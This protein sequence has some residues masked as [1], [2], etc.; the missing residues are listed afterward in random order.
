[1]HLWGNPVNSH[2]LSWLWA[3]QG[4]PP[5]PYSNFS[6]RWVRSKSIKQQR[7]QKSMLTATRE[8]WPVCRHVFFLHFC[9]FLGNI[10]VMPFDGKTWHPDMKVWKMWQENILEFLPARLCKWVPPVGS[11]YGRHHGASSSP[12]NLEA[13]QNF[14]RSSSHRKVGRKGKRK[15]PPPY[16]FFHCQVI[17]QWWGQRSSNLHEVMGMRECSLSQSSHPES[18]DGQTRKTTFSITHM[19]IW[20]QLL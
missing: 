13:K 7:G 14:T 4:P 18:W 5:C 20:G 12:A 10:L 8:K 15:V 11:S 3:S 6:Q 19:R 9:H 17:R 1:M 16:R 2:S